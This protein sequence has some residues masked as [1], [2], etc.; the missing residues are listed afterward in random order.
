MSAD[1]FSSYM[2]F[3]GVKISQPDNYGGIQSHE[4]DSLKAFCN[5]LYAINNSFYPPVFD[6]YF[7]GY[8]IPQIGKEFDLLRI[9]TE[10]VINVELKVLGSLEKIQRQLLKNKH[11]LGV[12][13]RKVKLF[14]Y[15]SEGNIL[16]TLQDD[17]EIAQIDI[18]DLFQDIHDQKLEVINDINT[19]FDPTHY[20]VSPFNSVD[21]FINGEYFLTQHQEDIKRHIF[22]QL[23]HGGV[24]CISGAAGTGKTLLIYDIAKSVMA[25]G[26]NVIIF[27]CAGLNPGQNE[28]INKHAW[29]ILPAKLVSKRD[30]TGV[31][32]IIIDEAQRA[33]FNQF[34][35]LR[36]KITSSDDGSCYYIFSYDKKQCMDYAEQECD[37]PSRIAEIPGVIAFELKEKIRTNPEIA[38]FIR[39]L[40]NRHL[41]TCK[42]KPHSIEIFCFHDRSH[43]RGMLQYLHNAGWEVL[44]YTPS[45]DGRYFQYENYELPNASSAH[46]VIGQEFDNVA[47]VIDETF[48]YADDGELLSRNLPDKTPNFYPQEKMLFQILTRT[49]KK[50]A[51]IIV[52]NIPILNRCLEILND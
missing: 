36:E 27:H 52:N 2:H 19:F 43:V 32:L 49:R 46:A 33:R 34:W 15:I 6:G 10:S 41:T 26:E 25:Q 38:S 12:I 3:L 50:I 48:Y 51:L 7:F 21:R 37:I 47:T 30:T 14:C 1:E 31:R 22:E 17:N 40:F 42:C 44:Q 11:Y 18:S 24:C 45:K 16:Y 23:S 8:S 20:L 9:G 39:A 5:A 28:L 29:T 4:L 13:G 35:A